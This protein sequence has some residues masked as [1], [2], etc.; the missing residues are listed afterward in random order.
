MTATLKHAQLTE[1]IIGVFYEVYN[2]LGSGFVESV[3]RE[4]MTIALSE[5]GLPV[6]R[7]FPLSVFFRGCNVGDFRID[8]LVNRAV[9]LE[10]KVARALDRSHEGQILNYLKATEIEVGLLLNFGHRPE[11]RRLVFSNEEK[12]IRANPRKSAVGSSS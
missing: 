3:Y 7:E 5:S 2:E 12:K 9:L 10:L 8:L 11:F 6:E 4:A 1:R